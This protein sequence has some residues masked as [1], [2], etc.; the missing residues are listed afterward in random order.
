MDFTILEGPNVGIFDNF[1][2]PTDCKDLYNL[3]FWSKKHNFQL[4]LVDKD[5]LSMEQ[6]PGKD[7]QEEHANE[8]RARN[9]SLDL[10]PNVYRRI[11][12]RLYK[13][14]FEAVDEYMSKIYPSSVFNIE[15]YEFNTLHYLPK[16][17]KISKHLDCYDYG[18]VFYAGFSRNYSGGDLY[19]ND[20]DITL[21]PVANRM[22]MIPSDVMHEVLPIES[23]YRVSMTTFVPVTLS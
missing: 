16:G 8:W 18:L 5:D 17:D 11:S 2:D 3:A 19:F 9:F 23:G 21:K 10:Y 13:K 15:H 7:R 12:E 22:L 20:H 1:L 4:N 14:S 6:D